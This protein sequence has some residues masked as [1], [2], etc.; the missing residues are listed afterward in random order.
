M[1]K[2][3]QSI[4]QRVIDSIKEQLSKHYDMTWE[5]LLEEGELNCEE[6]YLFDLPSDGEEEFGIGDFFVV[7][8]CTMFDGGKPIAI[9]NLEVIKHSEYQLAEVN[10]YRKIDPS[11]SAYLVYEGT[12]RMN[13]PELFKF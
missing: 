1:A 3:R 4:P 5:E 13:P 8:F 12:E 10:V 9:V 6:E 2:K 11:K 7:P